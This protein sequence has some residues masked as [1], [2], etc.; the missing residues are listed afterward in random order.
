MTQ[1][2]HRYDG[3]KFKEIYFIAMKFIFL[4]VSSRTNDIACSGTHIAS[5]LFQSSI[6]YKSFHTFLAADRQHVNTRR[7]EHMRELVIGRGR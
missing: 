7:R 3:G 1:V 5:L 2:D 6:I 4:C